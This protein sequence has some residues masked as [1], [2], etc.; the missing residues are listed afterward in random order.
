MFLTKEEE[1]ML[2]G[3][4]GPA[5]QRAMEILVKYGKAMRAERMIPIEHAHVSMTTP[6]EYGLG[7]LEEMVSLGAKVIVPSTS[8]TMAIDRERY[9]ELGFSDEFVAEQMKIINY[10]KQLGIELTF[11]CAPYIIIKPL[12]FG[13]HVAWCESSAITYINSIWGARTNRE[14]AQS[15]LLAAITGR[16]P[17]F[18]M[19]ITEERKGTHHVKVIAKLSDESD[20]SALGYYVGKVLGP[21]I[22]VFEGVPK[23]KFDSYFRALSAGL[24]LMGGIPMFHMIGVTPEAKTL[25]DAFQGDVP[26]DKLVITDEDLQST[27]DELNTG[28]DEIQ[29]VILGC[30][31]YS[32]NDL[33]WLANY[34]DN[35]K[36]KPGVKVWILTSYHTKK[37]AE[38]KG[39]IQRIETSGAMVISDTCP[40]L[41]GALPDLPKVFATNSAKQCYYGVPMLGS[42]YRFGPTEKVLKAAFTGKWV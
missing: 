26:E 12:K 11:T 15:A 27:Y 2:N 38:K 25:N 40:L 33:E 18:G 41:F 29:G 34:I 28:N 42:R 22:P 23:P 31:H 17:E 13:S 36:V 14:C 24:A 30:P 20:F 5:V 37:I 21:S 10:F 19:H 3:E 7:F 35:Q 8:Q 6:K 9:K 39:I 4:K 32:L 1:A 16:T